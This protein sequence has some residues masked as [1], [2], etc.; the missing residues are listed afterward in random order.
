[1]TWHHLEV[2]YDGEFE[3]GVRSG[4]GFFQWGSGRLDMSTF[5]AGA[6]VGEGVRWSKE[7]G[8]GNVTAWRLRDGAQEEEIPIEQAAE[9]RIAFE[10]AI[11]DAK[12]AIEAAKAAAAAD[13]AV[14]AAGKGKKK[15][16][17]K[18]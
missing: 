17:K 8:R 9:E 13:A 1:M 12:A 7:D 14:A 10:K 15:K 18:K 16:G 4:R 5:K 11:A 2:E 3:N 6:L